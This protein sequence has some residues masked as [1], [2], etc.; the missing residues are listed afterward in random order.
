PSPNA[1]RL[2]SGRISRRQHR[3][4]SLRGI[5][6]RKADPSEASQVALDADRVKMAAQICTIH[7]V[8]ARRLVQ[9][10][11]ELIATIPARDPWAND[12]RRSRARVTEDGPSPSMEHF[13]I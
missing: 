10:I 4:S 8:R 6:A 12:N 7:D 1:A 13:G 2:L 5:C 11:V 3:E 9:T